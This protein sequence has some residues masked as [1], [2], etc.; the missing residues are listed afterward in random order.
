[1]AGAVEGMEGEVD[2]GMDFVV[3]SA[4]IVS[5]WSDGRVELV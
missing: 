3:L 5:P 2:E 4:V 1:M